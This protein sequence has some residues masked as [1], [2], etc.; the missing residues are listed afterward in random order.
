[1]HSHPSLVKEPVRADLQTGSCH[2]QVTISRRGA[3]R[4]S[5]NISPTPETL[6][7]P[8]RR[9]PYHHG[10]RL[11]PVP[12]APDAYKTRQIRSVR[13]GATLSAVSAAAAMRPLRHFIVVFQCLQRAHGHAVFNPNGPALVRR[14]ALHAPTPS[15]CPG[16]R[17]ERTYVPLVHSSNTSTS[18]LRP[19]ESRTS[20]VLM[21]HGRALR[22]TSSPCRASLYSGWPFCL[23]AEYIGGICSIS[24]RNASSAC[25]SASP[26]SAGDHRSRYL[27][28][29]SSA[30]RLPGPAQT[31][32]VGLVCIQQ[33]LRKL[34]CLT[35]A[36]G[37]HPGRQGIQ[38]AR[39]A[40]L[41]RKVQD[42]SPAAMPG[43]NSR[44]H[45][46]S[47]T[48][49]PSTG[50]PRRRLRHALV[51]SPL[52]LAQPVLDQHR[53]PADQVFHVAATTNTGSK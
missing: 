1:M 42:A 29:A 23:I 35:K 49:M 38:A 45:G 9:A 52:S 25:T 22:S 43:W 30:S 4:P 47:S 33:V 21:H 12:A 46:L 2:L 3:T 17:N 53:S 24:P 13:P 41:G 34:G 44:R 5:S 50:R 48:R 37:Q 11:A 15:A 7:F 32:S 20:S 8:A 28:F 16:L 31:C 27:T 14:S 51:P 19:R 18:R 40:C 6:R 10:A 39:M 36:Q 26:T